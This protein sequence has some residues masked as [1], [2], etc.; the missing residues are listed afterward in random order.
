[1]VGVRGASIAGV[2]GSAGRTSPVDAA[3]G[4]FARCGASFGLKDQAT[5]LHV[6]HQSAA[7]KG[8]AVV[9]FQQSYEGVPV[10][11]SELNVQIDAAGAIQFVNGE[12]VS[13]IA[14]ATAP[15]V[16]ADNA[17]LAAAR[18]VADKFGVK[19]GNDLQ[20]S[21]PE[22]WIY[23]PTLI[24]FQGSTVLVWRMEV[25]QE[26]PPPIRQLVLVNAQDGSIALSLDQLDRARNRMTY[27]LNNSTTYPGTLRCNEANTN[28]TGGDTDEVNAHVFAADT[29]NFYKNYHARD[30]LNNAGMTLY[31]HVH[32]DVGYC[33]AFWNG[34]RM[35][36]GD[37]CRIVVDDVVA[38]EMTH[39]VT[40]YE[41]NLVY[42]NQS[43]AINESFSDIWGEFV[44]LT[45]GKGN[46]TAAVRW[47]MG[48]DVEGGA[49]RNMKN[50][51]QFGD[52]DR[53]GSSLYYKGTN[54]NGG[55]HTNSGV[56]N[57][58]A[59]LIT[60]GGTFNGRTVTGIGITKAAKIYYKVQ[61]DILTSNATYANLGAALSTA[62]NALVGTSAIT[63]A[64]C[65]QVRNATYAT[66]IAIP[67]PRPLTP[68]GIT[69]DTTPT[70]SWTKLTGAIAYRYTVYNSVGTAV[71][72]FTLP[73]SSCGTTSNCS[74][75][76]TTA[77]ARAD[78]SW[79]VQAQVSGGL[80]KPYSPLTAFT[81]AAFDSQFTTDAAGWTAVNGTWS[82]ASGYYQSNGVP[83]LFASSVHANNYGTLTYEVRMLRTA[84]N[85]STA[86][87]IWIRGTPSL[88]SY[89][90]WS[91]GY[92]FGY[93][94]T[95]YFSF[96]NVTGGSA[97]AVVNWTPSAAIVKN[98][99]N[100]LKVSINSSTGFTRLYIN[101]TAVAQGYLST[102]SKTTGR[103]GVAFYR[104]STAGHL[105]VDWANLSLSAP[106][107]I[108]KAFGSTAEGAAVEFAKATAGVEIVDPSVL[109]RSPN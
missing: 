51:P 18:A 27:D 100:T 3:R 105:N 98:G 103:V 56:G 39:G 93:T 33:N 29:Y 83:N 42:A 4:Y 86:N 15:T 12:L 101:N 9:K 71:Y 109:F 24:G 99:W 16:T 8:G 26:G 60:D 81:V 69:A 70:Y 19:V 32:Y 104:D 46:D 108:P 28:C 31:S 76:P 63:A 74:H 90:Y 88:S 20:T 54:D 43:G 47:L 34:S 7:E 107:S 21:A 30:S 77:L 62:C 25:S 45:N 48:E 2:A 41:S 13:D 79:K 75:T 6:K 72:S 106:A 84:A 87:S 85:T 14:L 11:A 68:I 92:L 23:D 96:Y 55:V 80:W 58:T 91:S 22:L 82:A 94:N 38:H 37:G 95:G 66:E 89:G 40:S 102:T 52:P 65:D 49:I 50:P 17:R 36:Y 97:G 67:N 44:D 78:Y 73:A 59:F 1:M 57:K 35:T 64:N 5:E 10:F 53:M 61:K